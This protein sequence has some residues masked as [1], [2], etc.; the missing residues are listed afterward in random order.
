MG[1]QQQF[2]KGS[3]REVPFLI[4]R[5][6][7]VFG[8]RIV[9]HEFPG[10]DIPFSEDLGRAIRDFNVECFVIGDDYFDQ[11][12]NLI[13]AAE[14]PGTGVLKH[15]Y[16]GT[17]NVVCKSLTVIDERLDTRIA[18][19]Q[20]TFRETGAFTFPTTSPDTQKNLNDSA[21]SAFQSLQTAFLKTYQLASE[22][23]K[24]AQEVLRALSLST[25]A[26][27]DAR[28]D[29]NQSANFIQAVKQIQSTLGE[30]ALTPLSLTQSLINIL[31]FGIFD[32]TAVDFIPDY[33]TAFLKL[34]GLFSFS[35][36][37]NTPSQ[38]LS[39]VNQFMQIAST[40]VAGSTISLINYDSANEAFNF[41][42][43][44]F[45]S[46]DSL[47][48]I[49]GLDDAVYISLEDLRTQ[50]DQDID[51]RAVILSQLTS[52]TLPQMIPAIVLSVQLYGT[53]DQEQDIINRNKI[54]H[55]GF[56]PA[57]VPIQVLLNA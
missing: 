39:T 35:P 31:S 49:D 50:I 23:Y 44:V 26:I 54:H 14:K 2:Q 10:Q 45:A 29:I 21:Q 57:V 42:D 18:K 48:L 51:A 53:V 22:P 8:R 38:S 20:F 9:E 4:D 6:Q 12:N 16:R 33:R 32:I 37:S 40:L 3:F 15:P 25:T 7:S 34:S 11:V 17:L 13:A 28:Q 5:G 56:I 47:M 30:L 19:L 41:R 36:P 52:I 43:I 1:W 55:P 46:I 27:Q 24:K